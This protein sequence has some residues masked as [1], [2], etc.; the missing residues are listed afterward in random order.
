MVAATA[1]FVVVPEVGTF[2]GGSDCE[3]I[4]N[5]NSAVATLMATGEVMV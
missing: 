4:R 3:L 5:G 2:I 1:M